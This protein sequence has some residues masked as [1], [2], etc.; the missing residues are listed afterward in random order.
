MGEPVIPPLFDV[1]LVPQ[2]PPRYA[3]FHQ[4]RI[5][6][7]EGS[8]EL[9][10][11]PKNLPTG[12]NQSRGKWRH[13]LEHDVESVFWL[14]VYWAVMVQ[15]ERHK[16]EPKEDVDPV[17][18]GSLIGKS[19]R[20][21]DLIGSFSRGGWLTDLTHPA[22]KPLAIL[23]SQLS[24]FL[25]VDRHWLPESDCRSKPEYLNEAFQRLILQ[26]IIENRHA[27]FM[28]RT[29][30]TTLRS[31]AEVPRSEART[32]SSSLKRDAAESDSE[33]KRRRVDTGRL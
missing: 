22:Y 25:V 6:N 11:S 20:R 33:V 7:F 12:D 18:W 30:D 16:K 28:D 24:S 8:K 23:I 13:G 29:I 2:S 26:F 10:I 21:D 9:I 5:K 3:S 27:S 1:P 4:E 31:T 19:E 14:L 32:T 15:P 17:L